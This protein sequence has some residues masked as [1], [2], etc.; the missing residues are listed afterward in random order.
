MY[1]KIIAYHL[2]V[3]FLLCTFQVGITTHYCCGKVAGTKFFVGDG[4][5]GCGMEERASKA[6]DDKH[7]EK[8]CCKDKLVKFQFQQ[9]FN[10]HFIKHSTSAN[11]C[12][13]PVYF[14][15][16]IFINAFQPVEKEILI[17]PP[18]ELSVLK[19][20]LTRLQVFRI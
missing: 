6:C 12:F 7:L 11:Q 16:A 4:K 18:P 8:D 13:I 17:P 3:L 1:R 10:S 5:V 14:F 15:T 2:L 20:S 9:N 19:E